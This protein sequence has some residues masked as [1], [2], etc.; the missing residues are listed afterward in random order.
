MEVPRV[1]QGCKMGLYMVLLGKL[2]IG[3]KEIWDVGKH[4]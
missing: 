3:N 2:L 4:E 1:G